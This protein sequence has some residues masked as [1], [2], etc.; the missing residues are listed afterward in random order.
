[1]LKSLRIFKCP[2]CNSLADLFEGSVTPV[3]CGEP[4]RELHPNT[5]DAA[6]EKHVPVVTH[7]GDRVVVR[8]G[9]VDHPMMEE[10]YIGYI[11]VVFEDKVG[12]AALH[13]GMEPYAEFTP[14]T[15]D[16]E[17]YEYCNIHGLWKA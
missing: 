17:V 8:V 7:N 1:M 5:V 4:M 13:P 2:H 12:R 15:G 14:G 16:V 6:L 11:W 9:S 10:H 3:C